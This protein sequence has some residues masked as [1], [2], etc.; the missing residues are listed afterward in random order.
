MEVVQPEAAGEES[1]SME[2]LLA[3]ESYAPL[4][5]GEIRRG[6]VIAVTPSHVV[7]DIHGKH[8]G[9]VQQRDLSYLDR[10]TRE[11]IAVGAEFPVYVLNPEDSEG[12]AIVLSLIHIS[13]PTRPY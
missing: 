9:F 12:R 3:D 13:E 10:T 4:Q 2:Q 6:V 5:R 7:L 8:E 1:P 11:Q